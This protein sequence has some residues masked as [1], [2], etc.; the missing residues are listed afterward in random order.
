[1]N[2][3][4]IFFFKPSFSVK[5]SDIPVWEGGDGVSDRNSLKNCLLGNSGNRKG[6]AWLNTEEVGMER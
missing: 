1:M 2:V 4:G 6:K 5:S 3:K